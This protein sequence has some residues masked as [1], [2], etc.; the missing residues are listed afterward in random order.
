[1]PDA[2]TLGLSGGWAVETQR[3]EGRGRGEAEEKK[4]FGVFIG[5]PSVE[6]HMEFRKREEFGGVVG[7]LREGAEKVKM[8]HVA[9]RRFEG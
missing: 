6:R 1:M 8:H 5:W 4:A 9:F 2:G 3:V 7:Y